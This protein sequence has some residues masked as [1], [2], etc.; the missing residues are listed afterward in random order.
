MLDVTDILNTPESVELAKQ[1]DE[2]M[3]KRITER[4]ETIQSNKK[5]SDELIAEYWKKLN[6]TKKEE[7]II[8][9]NSFNLILQQRNNTARRFTLEKYSDTLPQYITQAYSSQVMKRGI[10]PN[11]DTYTKKTISDISRWLLQRPKN[12][13]MLRGYVGV[14]KTTMLY[15]IKDI[16][17]ILANKGM[18]VKSALDISEL[19]KNDTNAFNEIKAKEILGIDDLGIEPQTVKNFGNESNPIIELLSYRYDNQLFTVI[20]TNLIVNNGVDEIKTRYGDR[21]A[22]RLKEMCNT[23]FYDSN[24]NSYRK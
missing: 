9:L 18:S 24:Q 5:E 8:D 23:I 16:L 22:D 11:L 20:T 2:E 14:G 4:N 10:Q 15:T 21:I 19:A 12:S 17:S 7:Y 3:M 13:I 6:N 1:R